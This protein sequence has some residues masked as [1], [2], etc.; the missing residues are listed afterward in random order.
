VAVEELWLLAPEM[1]NTLRQANAIFLNQWEEAVMVSVKPHIMTN[2][3]RGEVVT[4]IR[5]PPFEGPL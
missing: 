5:S 1:L 2:L 4:I 3:I